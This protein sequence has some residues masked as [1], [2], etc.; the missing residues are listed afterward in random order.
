[1]SVEHKTAYIKWLERVDAALVS[2]G[3]RSLFSFCKKPRPMGPTGEPLDEPGDPT[4]LE[5]YEIMRKHN[6]EQFR[7]AR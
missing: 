3:K 5:V 7:Y 2:E 4:V 1:M 6:I